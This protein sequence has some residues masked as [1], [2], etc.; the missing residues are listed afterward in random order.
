M[1]HGISAPL[2][3]ALSNTVK[4]LISRDFAAVFQQS[5]SKVNLRIIE[6]GLQKGTYESVNQLKNEFRAM[7]LDAISSFPPYSEL[8]KASLRLL[9]EGLALIKGV[10]E[11][12]PQ[13]DTRPCNVCKK[14]DEPE[15][16]LLCDT[17]ND[18]YHLHCLSCV[19]PMM[20]H[21]YRTPLREI[22]QEEWYCN[23]CCVLEQNYQLL[24]YLEEKSMSIIIS[25]AI[26][27]V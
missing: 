8:Y 2:K 11:Q 15:K 21:N 19:Y 25:N 6:E 14:S 22:P 7:C 3:Q 9:M 4:K 18:P 12:D 16:T 5:N 10:Q 17:C 13:E 24:S 26:Y 1:S 23:S 27:L 20:L